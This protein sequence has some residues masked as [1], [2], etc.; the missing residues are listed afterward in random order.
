MIRRA[1]LPTRTAVDP[2]PSLDP[3]EWKGEVSA[4]ARALRRDQL[5]IVSVMGSSR[6]RR[7]DP[8]SSKSWEREVAGD[9]V[10][11]AQKAEEA[12]HQADDDLVPIIELNLS[13]PN[14]LVGGV[15]NERSLCEYP[16][17]VSDIAEKVRDGMRRTDTRI[18]AKLGFLPGV[19]LEETVSGLHHY[20]DGIS[21]I[22]T[23]R[24]IVSSPSEGGPSG[25]AFG[26]KGDE[27]RSIA[28]VSGAALRDAALE[29][30]RTLRRLKE[31]FDAKY[32]ILAMGGVEA[33]DHALALLL[34]GATA[35]Q[36]ATG[37]F[38]NP[39][40]AVDIH[41]RMARLTTSEWN[42]IPAVEGAPERHL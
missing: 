15:L 12:L 2:I 29:F 27:S 33:P 1:G 9:F 16:H 20:I 22:N 11:V 35:V 18:V 28:G 30:V 8:D 37:P 14:V 36:G 3:E 26:D 38:F 42:E 39:R 32:E 40:L 19:H 23:V 17:I 41:E 31:K 21:G 34:A 10:R 24:C 25:P 13:A 4:S 5:L 7:T 6:R